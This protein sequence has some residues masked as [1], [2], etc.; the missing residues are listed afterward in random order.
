MDKKRVMIVDDDKEYLEELNE[1]LEM[2]GYE[3]VAVNDSEKALDVAREIR[4]DVILLDLKMPKKN[5]LQLA[6][7]F[8]RMSEL[9]GVLLIGISAF[10]KDEY[11]ALLD[12]CGIRRCLKKPFQPLDAITEIEEALM[13]GK[14]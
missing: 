7:D 14:R 6:V 1:M 10:Y 2:S 11:K 5:G 3:S 8:R 9:D 4:P 12:I 13:E